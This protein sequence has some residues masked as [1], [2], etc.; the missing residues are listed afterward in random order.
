MSHQPKALETS[1]LKALF[2]DELGE[3]IE[4][5]NDVLAGK[6]KAHDAYELLDVLNLMERRNE[7]TQSFDDVK[8]EILTSRTT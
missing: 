7:P 8:S 3:A 1:K 4:E 6:A 5:L 2:L